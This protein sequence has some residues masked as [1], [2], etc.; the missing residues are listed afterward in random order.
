MSEKCEADFRVEVRNPYNYDHNA[1]SIRTGLFCIEPSL[2]RQEFKDE[3]DINFIVET[4]GLTG[5]IPV[6]MKAPE[7]QDFEGIIDFQTAVHAVMAAEESFMEMPAN[8]RREFDNDPQRFLEFCADEGNLPKL[9]EWGLAMPSK[10]LDP[11]PPEPIL[12]RMVSE[13][14]K[15]P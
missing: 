13:P 3:C 1:V 8:V 12:V 11:P 14:P 15:A 6:G 4:Y 2:A 5:Q 10:G 7:Y 9:R